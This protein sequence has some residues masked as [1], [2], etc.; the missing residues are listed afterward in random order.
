MKKKLSF[1]FVALMCCLALLLGVVVKLPQ[2]VHAAGDTQL[3]H[4][5]T[6]KIT[7][8]PTVLKDTSQCTFTQVGNYIACTVTLSIHQSPKNG[9][10]WTSSFSAKS[11]FY[12]SCGPAY[13]IAVLP[14][15]GTLTAINSSIQISVIVSN[16]CYH[17]YENATIVF[18]VPGSKA[19]L[20]YSCTSGS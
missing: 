15:Q 12:Y 20:S 14:S 8:S 7:V 16:Y 3:H 6:P 5:S 13:D 2:S 9:V 4:A 17:G 1:V 10:H 11:C 18:A 19:Q